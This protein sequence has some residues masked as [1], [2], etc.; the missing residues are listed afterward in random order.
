MGDIIRFRPRQGAR[1]ERSVSVTT[2]TG[3]EEGATI[4]LF[5]GVRYERHQ[6]DSANTGKRQVR[7][8]SRR[9]RA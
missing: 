7:R 2:E 8:T 3:N 9:K 4:L 1:P 5:L 6:D